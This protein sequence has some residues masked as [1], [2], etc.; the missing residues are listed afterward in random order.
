MKSLL[1]FSLRQAMSIVFFVCL[2]SSF[3]Q[4]TF[5]HYHCKKYDSLIVQ[6]LYDERFENS[7]IEGKGDRHDQLIVG[8]SKRLFSG[9]ADE[10]NNKV[11]EKSSYGNSQAM[12]PNYDLRFL[13]YR[14]GEIKDKV[15]ISLETNNLF[16]SFPLRVQRQGDCMCR[17]NGGYCCSE[18]GISEEF[19]KYIVELLGD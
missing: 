2:S 13:Y 19:K 16:A 18:G 7:N 17:G 6:T 3:A 5:F 15:E 8:S 10:F 1:S 14:K 4:R 9:T 11:H 12:T